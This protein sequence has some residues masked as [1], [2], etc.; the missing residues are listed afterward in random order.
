MFGKQNIPAFTC[1]LTKSH[2]YDATEANAPIR[3]LTSI[4]CENAFQIWYYHT[5]PTKTKEI[6]NFNV[7]H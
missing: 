5:G 7:C 6:M 3:R 4:H 1:V 2:A